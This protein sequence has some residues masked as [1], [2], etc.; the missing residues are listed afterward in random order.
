MGR[1]KSMNWR[2]FRKGKNNKYYSEYDKW[3]KS[4]FSLLDCRGEQFA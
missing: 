3:C 1:N 4:V 2:R